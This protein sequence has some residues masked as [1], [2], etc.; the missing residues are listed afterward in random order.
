VLEFEAAPTLANDHEIGQLAPQ[1]ATELYVERVRVRLH[2]IGLPI[3]IV[4]IS[5]DH[6]GVHYLLSRVSILTV[7]VH[8]SQ[9]LKI[10]L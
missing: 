7:N 3:A 9:L 2:A 10:R 6:F 5:D 1:F 4:L 8:A